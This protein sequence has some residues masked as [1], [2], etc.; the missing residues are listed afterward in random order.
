[1]SESASNTF[2]EDTVDLSR[3]PDTVKKP[4]LIA[5]WTRP[6]RENHVTHSGYR[7]TQQQRDSLATALS[8]GDQESEREKGVEDEVRVQLRKDA[9]DRPIMQVGEGP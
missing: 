4:E 3:V 1:M 8:S 7:G 2:G 9:D 5:G 6:Q